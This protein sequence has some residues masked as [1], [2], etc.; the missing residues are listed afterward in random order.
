VK[1]TFATIHRGLRRL[2]TWLCAGLM[3]LMT[4]VILLQ[5][6]DS[7][8]SKYVTDYRTNGWTTELSLLLFVWT[9]FLG[10]TLGLDRRAHF[11]IN[12]LVN[13]L[14][15]LPQKITSIIA[16]ATVISITVILV[17]FGIELTSNGMAETFSTLKLG[18]YRIPRAAAYLAI[19]VSGALMLRY[20]LVNM[21]QDLFAKGGEESA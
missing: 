7:W 5:I 10:A 17:Y 11:G 9:T 21:W 8:I 18:T 13:A 3:L 1:E 15:K 6:A 14:P 2:E 4:A 19:P 20:T 12:L 16:Y